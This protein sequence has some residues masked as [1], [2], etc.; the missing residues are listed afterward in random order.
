M[1]SNTISPKIEFDSQ[2]IQTDLLVLLGLPLDIVQ[3][4]LETLVVMSIKQQVQGRLSKDAMLRITR[5]D[6]HQTDLIIQK[7]VLSVMALEKKY[8]IR[9]SE[10]E[11]QNVKTVGDIYSCFIK[12]GQQNND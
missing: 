5:H 1:D 7:K 9:L 11:Y 3:D 12:R 6:C 2:Q 8:G 10:V 4:N